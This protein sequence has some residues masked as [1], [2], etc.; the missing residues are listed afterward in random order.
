MHE[1]PQFDASRRRKTTYCCSLFA[2]KLE[3]PHRRGGGGGL[4]VAYVTPE[5]WVTRGIEGAELEKV[6]YVYL[7]K[8]PVQ[9][10]GAAVLAVEQCYVPVSK[11][12]TGD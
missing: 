3:G 2:I 4:R 12:H 7:K 6:I 1:L 11:R 5:I 10:L 9:P 8:R